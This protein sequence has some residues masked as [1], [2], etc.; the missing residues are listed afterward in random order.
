MKSAWVDR[1]A[2]ALVDRYAQDGVG[3][4]LA[5]R[6]YTTRLLP[7]FELILDTRS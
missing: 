7:G 1:E 4:E 3:A 2:A 6:I 5:L